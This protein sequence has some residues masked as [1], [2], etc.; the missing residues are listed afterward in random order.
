MSA[1]A[2][3]PFI[4]CQLCTHLQSSQQHCEKS[5]STLHKGNESSEKTHT[6]R[7]IEDLNQVGLTPQPGPQLNQTEMDKPN[8]PGST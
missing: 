2:Q 1:P 5:I 8:S 7:Q 4:K 6:L 3:S